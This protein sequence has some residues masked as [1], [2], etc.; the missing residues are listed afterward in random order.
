MD[1]NVAP[2]YANIFVA[3]LE[4]R[5]I[6]SLGFFKKVLCWLRYIDDVLLAWT[7]E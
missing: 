4:E 2:V 5:F 7:R 1:A 6:Y 3:D